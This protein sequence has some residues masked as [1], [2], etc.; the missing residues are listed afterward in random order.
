MAFLSLK[1][2]KK[3]PKDKS[4]KQ[5]VYN[6]EKWKKKYLDEMGEIRKKVSIA[7]AEVNRVKEN[8]KLTKRGRK[9]RDLLQ[10]ECKSLS[11]TQLITYIE[12]QKFRL[13]KLKAAFGR[14]KRQEEVKSLNDQFRTEPGWVYARIN[15]I[16]A[17]DPDNAHP[18]YKAASPAVEQSGG[19]KNMFEDI[20]EAEGF[21]R[22]L[23][24]EQGSGDE[25]A[26]WLK[27]IEE[28][29]RQRV[30]PAS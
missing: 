8:W 14:K 22:S 6:G 21:W 11:V 19:G 27:E 12:K 5:C 10:E 25:N 26:E 23:W 3:D 13:R 29:I 7:S 18:K 20:G 9:N 4:D 15:Q 17:E 30:P 16:V 28:A 2:W 1:G 24:E